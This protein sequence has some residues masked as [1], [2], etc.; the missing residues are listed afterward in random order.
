MKHISIIIPA[1]NEEDT[2]S[3]TI[4][5]ITS[6]MNNF[7]DRFSWEMIIVDDGSKDRTYEILKNA[8]ARDSHIKVLKHFTNMGQGSALRT[9]LP[10]TKGD[11]VVVMEADLNYSP[12]HIVKMIE[13]ME[14]D[15]LDIVLASA[16]A[17]EGIV[18]NVPFFRRVLSR[19]ANKFLSYAFRGNYSTLTCVVRCY[20]GDVI[21][22]L[23]LTSSGMEINL[24]IM[25]IAEILNL[26][27]GEVPAVLNW[28]TERKAT[29]RR[30]FRNLY[31]TMRRF[32]FYGFLIRPS[33]V[34]KIPAAF[35]MF[36]ALYFAVFVIFRIIEKAITIND[37]GL[38]Y[39]LS[40][41]MSHTFQTYPQTLFLCLINLFLSLIFL[42]FA[43]IGLQI[44][45]TYAKNYSLLHSIAIR[46]NIGKDNQCVE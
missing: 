45:Y 32:L 1:Y 44:K 26:K 13:K 11:I 17:R 29:G 24:E 30:S 43:F 9:A 36:W 16:Y 34:F 4:D 19:Y 35:F 46:Q 3:N 7:K 40:Q 20:R 10:H 42:L 21:R 28:S 6:Y 23:F 33:I 18:Q 38:V 22:D 39:A 15:N 25:E 31:R 2:I 27:V 37:N 5:S 8:A 12:E 14:S 41:G